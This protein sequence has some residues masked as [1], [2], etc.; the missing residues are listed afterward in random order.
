MRT[1]VRNLWF[2]IGLSGLVVR[3][4]GP[5]VHKAGAEAQPDANQQHEETIYMNPTVLKR[6]NPTTEPSGFVGSSTYDLFHHGLNE[7][8]RETGSFGAYHQ[9]QYHWI[10][11][12][13]MEYQSSLLGNGLSNMKLYGP[14]MSDTGHLWR[15]LG[16][17]SEHRLAWTVTELAAARQ[18]ITMVPMYDTANPEFVLSILQQTRVETVVVSDSKAEAF[19]RTLTREKTAVKVVILVGSSSDREKLLGTFPGLGIS[20][21]L[22]SEV[23]YL[24]RSGSDNSPSREDFNTICFTS[25]TTGE[26]KGALITHGMLISVV[27]AAV[28]SGIGVSKTDKYF[29]FL[30]P[31]HI[32]ERVVG[33]TLM[34][35]GA[36]IGY[37][38][39][40]KQDL[41]RDM[42]LVAPTLI[43]GVPRFLEKMVGKIEKGLH[44]SGT[45]ASALLGRALKAS[46][47]VMN[48]PDQSRSLSFINRIPIAKIRRSLG[49]K[50]RLILSGGG[51]LN[52]VTQ[53]KL[54]QYLH[55]YVVQGYG[56][57]ETTGGTLLQ[58]PRSTRTGAVGIPLSCVEL[59]LAHQDEYQNGAGELYVRGP[60]VFKG[61]FGQPE[62]TS[63]MFS[64]D[65][66]LK[67]GDVAVVS[68]GQ[69]E[70]IGRRKEIFKL[71]NGEY[72]VPALLERTYRMSSPIEDIY[73]D[74]FK[75]SML[76]GIINL[77]PDYLD[78]HISK[79]NEK[80][81]DSQRITLEGINESVLNSKEFG[82]V[83][84]VERNLR[85]VAEEAS[86]SEKLDG[87][88]ITL[89]PIGIETDFQTAT[90]KPKR[91]N[92]REFF[93]P[94]IESI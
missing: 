61:Y 13:D 3:V 35:S 32:F 57:T 17:Y 92:L 4:G 60:S 89:T 93:A 90:M 72:A 73:I 70:I 83:H 50:L 47:K 55:V 49:G 54:K 87:I 6:G 42:R 68:D 5:S 18:N 82:I 34:Y 20:I 69:F 1:Y 79:Y 76:F 16:I 48:H 15:M 28:V 67:T 30:P 38:S 52:P 23:K 94:I 78:V 26:P 10:T 31:A 33:L 25:G 63:E 64:H 81:P 53:K 21:L 12:K 24:G 56:M 9:G 75:G 85:I 27:G 14:I 51:P 11:Y 86:I 46:E 88:Y 65:G 43:A 44:R 80:R 59:K 40:S 58:H 36:K 91:R 8:G 19:L 62:A 41:A 22:M 45:F 84:A 39:G 2:S 66:W 37:F 77:K 29:A 74:I 7:A 71:P